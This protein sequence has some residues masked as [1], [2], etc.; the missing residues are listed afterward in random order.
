[1]ETNSM[2]LF[3]RDENSGFSEPPWPYKQLIGELLWIGTIARPDICFAVNTLARYAK[4]PK[5]IHWEA[6]KRVL[7]YLK[8]SRNLGISYGGSADEHVVGYSDSDWGGD[9]SDRKSISGFVFMYNGGPIVWK[10]KKQSIVA[11]ST[12]EAEYI[13]VSA[14]TNEAKWLKTFFGE[15]G[16]AP[17]GP[18]RLHVD[19]MAVINMARNPVYQ[20]KTKH[21]DIRAHHV[22]DE[23]ANGT[24]QLEYIRTDLNPADVFTKPLSPALHEK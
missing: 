10:S 15:I 4:E 24:I 5:E 1:M 18:I 8:G 23:T 19:N 22:R 16:Q 12:A 17:K 9:R 13:A 11:T 7:R 21:I 20:S 14:A 2:E 3:E 6:A